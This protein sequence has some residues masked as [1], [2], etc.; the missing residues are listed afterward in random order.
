MFYYYV[1]S[2]A[3]LMD[4]TFHHQDPAFHHQRLGLAFSIVIT[5]S[6]GKWLHRVLISFALGVVKTL[7]EVTLTKDPVVSSLSVQW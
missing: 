5:K 6:E 3:I 4:D 1:S 7:K 2:D